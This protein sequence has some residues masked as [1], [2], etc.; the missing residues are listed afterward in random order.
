MDLAHLILLALGSAGVLVTALR[1]RRA[2]RRVESRLEEERRFLSTVLDSIKDGVAVCDEHGVLS[3]FNRATTEMHGLPQL[4]VS[5]EHWSEQ[6]DLYESDGTTPMA[7]ERI[8][9]YRAWKGEK[10]E[11]AEMVI[12]PPGLPAR[13]VLVNGRPMSDPH[14]HRIGAVVSLH[15]VTEQKRAQQEWFEVHRIIETSPSIVF[16]WKAAEGWPVEYVSE[17]VEQL[18]YSARE[19][20]SGEVAFATIIHPDDIERVGREV[21][22]NTENG[23]DRFVQNYRIIDPQ[24]RTHWIDDWTV[25][26]RDRNGLP[27][28]YN[29]IV[30]DVTDR[31]AIGQMLRESEERMELALQGADLGM[32]D[33][34]LA[35]GRGVFNERWARMLGYEME[36]IDTRVDA[37][38]RLIHPEDYDHVMETLRAHLED[39]TPIYETEHRLR[40]KSGDWIWVLDRGCV[41]SRDENGLPMRMTGTHLDIT[42]R[43]QAENESRSLEQQM[44]QAQKLESLGMMAGG[45]AHDFNNILMAIL[46]NAELARLDLPDD[47]P[48]TEN[49][50]EIESAA[51]RAAGL[52]NQMLAYSGKGRY[53]VADIDLS[54][55]VREIVRML[56]SVIS[57][58][59]EVKLEL[60]EDLPAVRADV[61]QVRQVVM[62]LVTNASEAIGDEPGVITIRTGTQVSC[63]C[64]GS[65]DFGMDC[66]EK[67]GPCV[68]LEVTDTGCGMDEDTKARLFEPFFT[69]KFTGR[70]L[71]MAAV[72]GIIR[73]HDG[74][75]SIDTA[76]D[77]GTTVTL[78]LPPGT[79]RLNT[80]ETKGCAA[81]SV[82]TGGR[83]L[84]VDDEETVLGLGRRLLDSLGLEVATAVDGLDAMEYVRDNPGSLD[85]VIMDVT[86][87]RMDGIEALERI[88]DLDPDLPVILSS[89]YHGTEIAERVGHD[90]AFIQKPYRRDDL[91]EALARSR[92]VVATT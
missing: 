6:Y 52:C 14:G 11:N 85:C 63:P 13:Q 7:T 54:I 31:E 78:L 9:L 56:G 38:K 3:L 90:V 51:S 5:S 65:V 62:N 64:G 61:T 87:P 50:G 18:G 24:G 81:A 39:E 82:D 89:G 40:S 75:I 69:T 12:A 57:K 17:N 79:A 68:R 42:A 10:V 72:L 88:R 86:M 33:W 35:T 76:P 58:K 73:G 80:L 60:D 37:W 49:L 25:I 55:E 53:Q 84:L 77:D 45:I 29:G 66:G 26:T 16:K 36:D 21:A 43:K 71:G 67:L 41:T 70:G 1:A 47:S 32:W 28:H 83:I 27:T 15:D 46:G 34:D 2:R 91:A 30:L 44:Q 20:L 22:H 19:F 8:P 48:A 74:R 23:I 92:R 59:V 4:P